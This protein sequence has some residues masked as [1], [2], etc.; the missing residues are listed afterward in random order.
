VSSTRSG[1]GNHGSHFGSVLVFA[2]PQSNPFD[3]DLLL[4]IRRA[5][6]VHAFWRE[7]N[8]ATFIVGESGDAADFSASCLL[9]SELS[10][11]C[12]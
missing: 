10:L 6:I 2:T 11:N 7:I 4:Q 8:D 5:L 1:T 12:D 3:L 9:A